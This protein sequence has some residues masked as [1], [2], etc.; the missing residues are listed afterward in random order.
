MDF[1]TLKRIE[2]HTHSYYSNIRLLDSINRPENL[3]L[4]AYELGLSGICLT[5]HECLC[6]AVDWLNLEKEFKKKGKIPE[7]F[8]CGIGNE[9]YLTDTREKKQKYY[10]FILIAKDTIGFHQLCELSSKSWYNSYY[11]RGMERVPTL[12]SE[13]KELVERNKG[14]IIASNACLGGELPQLILALTEAERKND[15]ALAAEYRNKIN[16]FLDYCVDLFGDD[17][18]IEVAPGTSKDQVI[19]N[20]RVVGIARAYGIKMIYGTDA[21]YLTKEERYIHKAYLNSKEGEREID[22]F[23][24]FAHLMDNNEAWGYFQ[25]SYDDED[26]MIQF[27]NNSMEIYDKIKGYDIFRNPIIPEVG[28][29]NYP[30]KKMNI[31][32]PTLDYLFESD[33]IQ[34]RYWIN[35]CWERMRELDFDKKQVYIHRLE[36]EADII[37]TVGD[38]LGN[39]LFEYFN[40]FQHFIDLFWECGSIVGPGRGSSVCFLSNYLMGI[41]Q[42]DP[43]EW[44]LAEW[45]FLNK[46]RLEL[47][48]LMLILGSIKNVNQLMGVRKIAC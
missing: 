39:C 38:K 21:H 30:Q 11:D 14:H 25:E 48:S 3:I 24:E 26:L 37:K 44:G 2:T 12:K 40:T 9:I 45:R 31:G 29:P 4:K 8:K 33:N 7:D 1:K 5:D 10:H 28:V 20:K 42:L 43:I 18:Y 22:S 46:D 27:C 32:E 41:T 35:Q 19:Y 16:E 13:L 36:I 23:Y 15:S 6:G 17:F 47:P 34:E